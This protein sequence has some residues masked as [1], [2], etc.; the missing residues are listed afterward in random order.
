MGDPSAHSILAPSGAEQLAGCEGSVMMQAQHPEPGDSVA[1]MEG[2]AAHWVGSE[3]LLT[4]IMPTVGTLAPN[5][6]MV[7]QTMVEGAQLWVDLAWEVLALDPAAV[8]RVEER[9]DVPD[10]HPLCYGTPDTSIWLPTLGQVHTLEYKYGFGVVEAYENYQDVEYASGELS[11]LKAQGVDVSDV[12]VRVHIIQPRAWHP[13]GRVRSWRVR[14]SDMD[15][16]CPDG[17]IAVLRRQAERAL[18]DAPMLRAGRHCKH[19]TA[20][21]ACAAAQTAALAGF[22]YVRRAGST[23]LD[24]I[25]LGL[26]LATLV[27]AEA[28]IK[29][30]RTG[31]EEQA[32]QTLRSGGAVPG[33]GIEHGRGSRKWTKP[34]SEVIALGEMLGVQLA[35]PAA[36]ITP[37]QAAK[38]IDGSVISSYS[39]S[40]P[41]A[42]SLAQVSKSLALQVFSDES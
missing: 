29:A 8:I 30:R 2:T 24:P 33:W 10:V 19:C 6:V 22:E 3:C 42:A 32:L 13:L 11:R 27:E 28:A 23:P 14:P 21:H 7:D 1:S 9:L 31:L 15:G 20:R 16:A 4:G 37:T 41:G 18:G 35:K 36:A 26:E 12:V 34:D 17:M 38:L 40:Y 39:T 5:G 25:A